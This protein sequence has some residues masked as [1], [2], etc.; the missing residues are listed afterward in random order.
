METKTSQAFKLLDSGNL[1]KALSIFKTFKIGLTEEER[2]AIQI[3]QE[4]EAGKSNFYSSLG[5]DINQE[6]SKALNAINNLR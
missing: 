1:N 5:I 2:R 4:C 6:K 3:T